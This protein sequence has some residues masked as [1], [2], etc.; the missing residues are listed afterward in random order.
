[1][2]D[3]VVVSD[4]HMG[5]GKNP[6]TGR[7]VRLEAFFYDEDFV[8][9]CRFLCEDATKR[10]VFFKLVLN[11]DTFDLLRIEPETGPDASRRERRFGPAMTPAM[12]ARTVTAILE[13]HPR[14]VDAIAT[15]L[16]AGHEVVFL[17]GNHDIQIQWHQVRDAI[18]LFVDDRLR[19]RT[20]EDAAREAMGRLTFGDWFYYEE[21]R[22]WIEHGC[23]YDPDNSFEYWLRAG[24]ADMPEE[25]IESEQDYPLG[26]FFQRYLYNA[27]GNLT[28]IVPTS[29]SNARYFKWMLLNRPRLLARVSYSHF[30]FFF[31]LVRRMARSGHSARDEL[32]RTHRAELGRLATRSG[33]GSRL[34]EV[35]ALKNV[36]PDVGRALW[37]VTKQV[38][39][40]V[41]LAFA[42]AMFGTGLWFA[43]FHAIN[44]IQIGFGLKAFLFLTLNFFLL[45]SAAVG[46]A[47]VLLRGS[48]AV[49][50]HPLRR[51]ARAIG[52]KLDVPI[53]AFGHSHEEN[54]APLRNGKGA[55]AW[56]YNTGTWIAVFTHDQLLPRE[57]VQFTYLHIKGDE[58]ELVY[59]SPGR[60][61]PQPV[62][63]LEDDDEEGEPDRP[64]AG[65]PS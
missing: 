49:S 23:Q 22:V 16:Q 39:K 43:G 28:F 18:R 63:L 33:I 40:F 20:G 29:T 51:A 38:L 3:V 47:Y 59:W 27:F 19:A 31:Q 26:S 12:A 34:A 48:H 36:Q 10:D 21:R 58:A 13:G 2:H 41:L 62:V 6:R 56:Y 55:R 25:V 24:L 44:Q 7:Y 61:G 5:R 8:Q 46:V 53:V 65:Q 9:F 30:P 4:L 1:M 60:G 37:D 42:V 14:F 17:P 35:E 57:R 15:V 64:A 11:G 45:I 52:K 32:E 54:V 50:P